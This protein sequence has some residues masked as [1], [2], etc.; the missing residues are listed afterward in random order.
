M[1]VISLYGR[2]RND[3][4]ATTGIIAKAMHSLGMYVQVITSAKKSYTKSIIKMDKGIM[5]SKQHETCDIALVLDSQVDIKLIF[6]EIN[7]KGIILA[8]TNEKPS[9]PSLK[10]KSVKTYSLD[11]TGISL[12]L[13]N[14]SASGMVMAGALAK[15][16]NKLTIKA[17]KTQA[18]PVFKEA[19]SMIDEGYRTVR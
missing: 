18:E 1:I 8:N 13:A 12:R 17:L 3:V 14:N 15:Y 7:S 6:N 4:A 11:A 16:F 9:L 10:N 5:T 19:S 2:N